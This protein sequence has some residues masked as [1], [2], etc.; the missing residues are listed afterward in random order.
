[1]RK[2]IFLMILIGMG[3]FFSGCTTQKNQPNTPTAPDT[4]MQKVGDTS[5]VG[6]ISQIGEKFYF[7]EKGNTPQE[8]DSYSI[9]LGEYLGKEVV[10][11]GQYSGDTLFVG[12]VN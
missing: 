10:I 6:V 8:I 5:K 4:T 2:N 7:S 3:L 12:S 9:D 1:M 11:T